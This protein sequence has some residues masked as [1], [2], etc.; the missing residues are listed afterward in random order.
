[1]NNTSTTYILI[2]CGVVG[3]Y[4]DYTAEFMRLTERNSLRETENQHLARYLIELSNNIRDQM[5]LQPV[6]DIHRAKSMA[7]RA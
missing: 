5:G 3:R 4:I 7:L 1:M 6:Y 2:V